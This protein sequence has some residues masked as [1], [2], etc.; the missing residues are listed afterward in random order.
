MASFLSKLFGGGQNLVNV[1]PSQ[2]DPVEH[3]GLTIYPAPISDGEQWRLAGVI[4]K[5]SDQGR[6]ERHYVRA[7]VFSSYEEAE[8][9]SVRKGK[10][11]IEEQ[12]ERL[13][14]DGTETGQA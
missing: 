6:L 11:I 14:A 5:Q 9:F 4:I 8:K 3:K 1:A 13:F 7:D 2:G 12:D 10:Q